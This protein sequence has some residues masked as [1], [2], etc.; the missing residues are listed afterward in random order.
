VHRVRRRGG[1]LREVFVDWTEEGGLTERELD[2]VAGVEQT[3]ARYGAAPEDGD[4][5]EICLDAAPM[6]RALAGAI[7]RGVLFIVDYG[8]PAS[9]LYSARHR[10]G[11]LLAYHRHAAGED[12]LHRVGQ[13]DLTAHVNFTQIEDAAREAGLTVLG[14][15]TQDRFLIGNGILDH[16]RSEAEAAWRDPS[17]VRRRLQAMQLIHPSGMG[18]T[19]KVLAL[20]KGLAPPPSLAGLRDPFDFAERSGR[21]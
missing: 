17:R 14:L 8:Y 6:M 2:P 20:S 18:R 3:A 11:T 1:S 13:Q 15:T 21:F 4:E 5:S 7:H 19:F 9:E 10:R 16:F 12:Y